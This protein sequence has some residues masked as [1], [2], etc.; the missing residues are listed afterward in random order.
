LLGTTSLAVYWVHIELVYGRWFSEYK[1]QLTVW[2]CV[3]ASTALI[4]A[5]V[6]MSA[7]IRRFR[8]KPLESARRAAA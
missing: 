1:G 4:V 8:R 3:A 5:M 6:G 2:G 7:A